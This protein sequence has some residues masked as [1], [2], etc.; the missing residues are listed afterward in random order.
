MGIPFRFN[1][2]INIA[3]KS[4]GFDKSPNL[5]TCLMFLFVCVFCVCLAVCVWVN[6]WVVAFGSLVFVVFLFPSPGV[7]KWGG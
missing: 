6:G 4:I 5:A 1:N 7:P 2:H 3:K